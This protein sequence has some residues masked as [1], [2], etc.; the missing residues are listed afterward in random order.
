MSGNLRRLDKKRQVEQ[1]SVS[2]K[3]QIPIDDSERIL[4]HG[5]K[6]SRC[7]WLSKKDLVNNLACAN[8]CLHLFI[9]L[10]EEDKKPSERRN[11]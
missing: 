9:G 6:S 10:W 7:S 2:I 8:G 4:V 5:R 1:V 11:L 3:P